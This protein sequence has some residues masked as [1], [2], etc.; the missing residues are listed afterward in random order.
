MNVN[1]NGNG[2]GNG[3][4]T[5]FTIVTI[6]IGYYGS[7]RHYFVIALLKVNVTHSQQTQNICITFVQCRPNVFDVGP[8]LYKV[9]RWSNIVQMLYKYLVFTGRIDDMISVSDDR[10]LRD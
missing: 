6:C 10:V 4:N 2:N 5:I 9:T 8:T 3:N 7:M 1:G